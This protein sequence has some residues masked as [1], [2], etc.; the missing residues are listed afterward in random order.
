MNEINKIY[1]VRM[2]QTA[3]REFSKNNLK[4]LQDR[5]FEQLT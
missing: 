2:K 5:P 3:Y 4:Y 1:L